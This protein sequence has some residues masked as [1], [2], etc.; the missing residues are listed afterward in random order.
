M[1]SDDA[2]R[3]R[4]QLR[5]KRCENFSAAIAGTEDAVL[6]P[7]PA[8]NSLRNEQQEQAVD[9]KLKRH[10]S[11]EGSCRIS[12]RDTNHCPCAEVERDRR[13][14]RVLERPRNGVVYGPA[15]KGRVAAR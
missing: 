2:I 10:F 6:C 13:I 1:Q 4:Q 9:D 14:H 3:E 15:L 12:T 11:P 8:P 5:G 7:G